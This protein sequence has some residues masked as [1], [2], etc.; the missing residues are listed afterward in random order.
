MNVGLFYFTSVFHIKKRLEKTKK[1]TTAQTSIRR[2][3]IDKKTY[4]LRELDS[5]RTESTFYMDSLRLE[6]EVCESFSFLS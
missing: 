4:I 5:I 6:V 3:V 1:L 2:R